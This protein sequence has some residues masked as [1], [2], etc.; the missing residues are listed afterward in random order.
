MLMLIIIDADMMP[1]LMMPAVAAMPFWCW[2]LM[3]YFD[4]AF[5]WWCYLFAILMIIS[6]LILRSCLIIFISMLSF[7]LMLYAVDY[8]DYFLLML[9]PDML[10]LILIADAPMP[11]FTPLCRWLLFFAIWCFDDAADARTCE[12]YDAFVF[13]ADAA[14]ILL[15]AYYS[16][17]RRLSLMLFLI[18][19][20]IIIFD[21]DSLL[22]FSFDCLIF[23]PPL[24]CLFFW[25]LRRYLIIQDAYCDI[26]DASASERCGWFI[27]AAAAVMPYY[28]WLFSLSDFADIADALRRWLMPLIIHAV[29]QDVLMTLRFEHITFCWRWA[30]AAIRDVLS[31]CASAQRD[32]AI[33]DDLRA[34]SLMPDDADYWFSS[35]MIISM[36]ITRCL[37]DDISIFDATRDARRWCRW[38]LCCLLMTMISPYLPPDFTIPPT[39]FLMM[40]DDRLRCF[41]MLAALL[42]MSCLRERDFDAH[43]AASDDAAICWYYDDAAAL[44]LF[45]LIADD[46]VRWCCFDAAIID[47]ALFSCPMRCRLMR[48]FMFLRWWCRRW[49]FIARDMRFRCRCR[50]DVYAAFILDDAIRYAWFSLML[51]ALRRRCHADM[52]FADATII[53]RCPD[54]CHAILMMLIIISMPDAADF[55]RWRLMPFRSLRCWFDADA[56]MPAPLIITMPCW[57]RRCARCWLFRLLHAD[58]ALCLRWCPFRFMPALI[59]ADMWWWLFERDAI[60]RVRWWYADD[61]IIFRCYCHSIILSLCRC[62][63]VLPRRF[64]M[65]LRR[66]LSPRWW[67][68]WL[69]IDDVFSMMMPRCRVIRFIL[70]YATMPDAADARS[71][72]DSARCHDACYYRLRLCSMPFRYAFTIIRA[73][74]AAAW[75]LIRLPLFARWCLSWCRVIIWFIMPRYIIY[76]VLLRWCL[77][78]LMP[79]RFARCAITRAIKMM[80]PMLILRFTTI[81]CWLFWCRYFIAAWCRRCLIMPYATRWSMLF[82]IAAMMLRC[83]RLMRARL[84]FLMMPPARW[85]RFIIILMITMPRWCRC[86]MSMLM[87]RWLFCFACRYF[88]S[89]D[90]MMMF[91]RCLMW[92]YFRC[93]YD[94]DAIMPLFTPCRYSLRRALRLSFFVFDSYWLFDA[95]DY[96]HFYARWHDAATFL[97]LMLICIAWYYF[98]VAPWCRIDGA[99]RFA[100]SALRML[101]CF[102]FRVRSGAQHYY[103]HVRCRWWLC[104]MLMPDFSLIFDLL[105]FWYCLRCDVRCYWF[106]FWCLMLLCCRAICWWCKMI[107]AMLSALCWCCLIISMMLSSP[108]CA[109]CYADVLCC[110][111]C[112]RC[113]FTRRLSARFLIL[114]LPLMFCRERFHATMRVV[115]ADDAV[116][117]FQ[118]RVREAQRVRY[119]KARAGAE[120]LCVRAWGVRKECK[121]GKERAKMRVM[122]RE[123]AE[124]REGS[125]S[126]S[127]IT[128]IDYR[129]SPLSFIFISFRL[130]SLFHFHISF[131][132]FHYHFLIFIFDFH[133]SFHTDFDYFLP[134]SHSS[135]REV[136]KRWWEVGERWWGSF[137]SFRLRRHFHFHYFS[138]FFFFFIISF[139]SIS[140]HFFAFFIIISFFFFI[141]IIRL[142]FLLSFLSFSFLFSSTLSSSFSS[143]FSSSS[144]FPLLSHFDYFISHWLIIIFHFFFII[145][146]IIFSIIM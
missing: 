67:Y 8:F 81:W 107:R 102:F 114:R 66:L 62:D 34:M 13:D 94:A 1:M 27:I 58:V 144:S 26:K 92:W 2:L 142:F 130:F 46:I 24:R 28:V 56:M 105:R 96:R 12:R 123:E 140:F 110:L 106:L 64:A 23:T 122:A 40:R 129:F 132:S 93:R 36:L 112:F 134:S 146:I 4:A 131:I 7:C 85:L 25:C 86:F 20:D 18:L 115:Y 143:S 119:E 19:F 43:D 78:S 76:Y 21:A 74:A 49:C 135:M 82:D 69:I 138:S 124:R 127:P 104:L 141:S 6:M 77:M 103:C 136:R 29:R 15:F 41:L 121:R 71:R 10:M 90:D 51:Y 87:P 52:L 116:F 48:R 108:R 14:V 17:P 31:I 37:C 68:W 111:I 38:W 63:T 89:H 117:V 137:T 65:T 95:F 91:D 59:D 139:S 126:S 98:A 54:A 53:F 72:D 79:R 22:L 120:A 16:M 133:F 80:M 113:L 100:F 83:R 145:I 97:M 88:S 5:L 128:S 61:A 75:C 118:R 3:F 125:P 32:A 44:M 30:D 39:P 50:D 57:C 9:L 70:R 99:R 42:P 60:F 109:R 11:M 45:T 73:I 47:G 101:P 55:R 84:L 35:S 33:V